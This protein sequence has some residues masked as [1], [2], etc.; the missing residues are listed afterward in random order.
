MSRLRLTDKDLDAIAPRIACL[1]QE[2]EDGN[3]HTSCHQM[4]TFFDGGPL[5]NEYQFCPYCGLPLKE[6]KEDPN[7]Y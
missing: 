6:F 3:W 2:D 7:D 1:W 5:D 4:H